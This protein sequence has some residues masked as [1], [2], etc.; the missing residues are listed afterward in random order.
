LIQYFLFSFHKK[1]CR[2]NSTRLGEHYES[3]N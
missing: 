2:N 3:Q 1:K